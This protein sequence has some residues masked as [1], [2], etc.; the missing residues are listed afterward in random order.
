MNNGMP[1][2]TSQPQKRY[3]GLIF[4]STCRP[5]INKLEE[6]AI[7]KYSALSIIINFMI[8]LLVMNKSILRKKI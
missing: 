2:L 5:L 6:K 3:F 7:E 4:M 1:F 8:A